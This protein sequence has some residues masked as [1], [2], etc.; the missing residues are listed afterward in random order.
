[1]I[2]INKLF[3]EDKSEKTRCICDI[4]LNNKKEKIWFEVDKKYKEYLV[5]DRADA[6]I[7]GILNYALRNNE[8]IISKIPIT[9]EL[10]YNLKEI[11]IPSL[12]KNSYALNMISIKANTIEPLKQGE[13]I[14]TGCSCGVDSFYSIKSHYN[15]EY[16]SLKLTDLC[17][18]N[19]G[20]FNECYKDYG[21]K[22]TITERYKK[23]EKV[24]KDLG[25]N[26]IETDSNFYE[27]VPQVHSL[28]HTYSSCFAIYMLQKYWKVYFYSSSGYD[29]TSFNLKNNDLLD[30][31]EYELLSLQTFSTSSIKI[32]SDGGAKERIEKVKEIID[33]PIAQKELHVCVNK[34]NNC[35]ICPKCMRTI[36]SLDALNSLEKFSNVFDIK[37][38]YENKID[39]YNW[40]WKQHKLKDKMNELTYKIL[41]KNKDFKVNI[42][43]KIKNMPYI[44][45]KNVLSQKQKENIKKILKR[46]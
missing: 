23:T 41:S 34:S 11:L 14:G 13:H 29:F 36:L 24:A 19:V 2:V 37:Y 27:V 17:I 46:R 4:E 21:I 7:I 33:F 39:Y 35:G 22:R 25:I 18:N 42:F 30:C 45:L 16:K 9:D 3:T 44:I 40:L 1:M 20:A 6:I 26:L 31:A 43:F 38:Y 15:D 32:Y 28:T 8:D 10:L 12:V 5:T